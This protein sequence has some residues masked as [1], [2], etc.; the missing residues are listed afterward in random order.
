MEKMNKDKLLLVDGDILNFTVCRITEDITD[1]G[2][3]LLESFDEEATIRL[4]ESGLNAIAEKTGYPIENIIYALSDVE[5]FRKTMFPTYKQNRKEVRKPLGLKFLRKHQY[6]NADKYQI[7]SMTRLEADDAM[8]IVAT[9][10][11]ENIAIYSQDKD[12]KTIPCKQWDFKLDKFITLTHRQS[13][14][15]LYTQLLTGD[16]CDGIKGCKRIGK[17]KAEKALSK[18]LDERQLLEA[19]FCLYAKS[20]DFDIEEAKADLLYNMGQ[21][22]ILHNLDYIVLENTNK[23]YNPF[24]VFRIDKEQLD[25]W[26]NYY[27]EINVKA[28]K[29]VRKKGSGSKETKKV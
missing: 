28:G 14:H 9:A 4:F 29:K 11:L 7:L 18:C 16:T 15:F 12:L 2:D 23:T 8:G 20:H 10:D 26:V 22:R 3:T 6:D 24:N 13:C 25:E 5:N 19:C 21:L 17:V 1:F 27:K